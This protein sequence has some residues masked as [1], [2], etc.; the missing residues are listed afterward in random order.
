MVMLDCAPEVCSAGGRSKMEAYVDISSYFLSMLL[1]VGI[2]AIFALAEQ[3]GFMACLMS[4]SSVSWPWVPMKR[5]TKIHKDTDPLVTV[6][7]TKT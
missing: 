1:T 5:R 6:G 4:V 2:Y 7:C 3:L